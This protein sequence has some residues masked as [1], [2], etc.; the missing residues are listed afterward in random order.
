MKSS[1]ILDGAPIVKHSS[2]RTHIHAKTEDHVIASVLKQ[3]INERMSKT[4]T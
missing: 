3:S 1:T 4:L 2:M